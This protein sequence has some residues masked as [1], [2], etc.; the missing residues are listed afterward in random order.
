MQC[1]QI[2]GYLQ[3][4]SSQGVEAHFA[5]GEVP[6][7]VMQSNCSELNFAFWETSLLRKWLLQ[8]R[9]VLSK[10]SPYRGYSSHPW[11]NPYAFGRARGLRLASGG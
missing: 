4:W 7:S 2:A 10:A 1:W 5:R 8:I 11:G 3:Q 9:L 6:A